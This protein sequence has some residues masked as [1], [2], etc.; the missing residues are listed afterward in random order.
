MHELPLASDSCARAATCG[1]S[2]ADTEAHARAFKALGDPA[3]LRML[4]IIASA[5]EVCVC[6]ITPAFDLSDAT[7]S[8]HLK[9]LREAGLVTSQRRGTFVHYAVVPDAVAGLVDVLRL[10]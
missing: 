6:D 9:I 4:S 1:L 5:P 8:H 2:E 7:V 10:S 3:R